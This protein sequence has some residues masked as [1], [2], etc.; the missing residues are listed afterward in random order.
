MKKNSKVSCEGQ[1]GEE[2]D[3]LKAHDCSVQAV[4]RL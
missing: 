4:E 2:P 3:D 1:T